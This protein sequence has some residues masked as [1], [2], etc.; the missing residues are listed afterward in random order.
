MK[1]LTR[2]P[3]F[4]SLA[5]LAAP[6]AA[7]LLL[8]TLYYVVDLYF[9]AALGDAPLA[10][11]SAAGNVMFLVFALT[12]IV[13]VG[14]VSLVSQAVGR[15][16]R[17]D[18][19][20][21]FNQSIMLAATC[22]LATL[23]AGYSLAGTYMRLLG[24]DAS[25]AAAGTAYLDWF[26]PGLALQFALVVMGSALRGTG[27][28]KPTMVV[29]A[30]TVV[31]NAA[32]APVLIAGW[33]TGRPLGV[34]GAGLASSVSV[35]AGV[36]VLALYFARFEKYV[37]FDRTQWRPRLRTWIRMLDV[38]IPAGGE[39]ALIGLIGAVV[40]WIIRD[41]G[42]AAQAGFGIGSR[43]M[44]MIFVPVLAIA[45]AAAPM[46]GQNFGAR[47]FARVRATF[48]AAAG[49]I[50]VVMTALLVLCQWKVEWLVRA[51][52]ADEAVV[53]F[54][55]QYLRIISWNFIAAGIVFTCS[56]IFQGLGNTRPAL[57]SK[58]LRLVTFVVPALWLSGRPGFA[59]VDVWH[60]S[61]ASTVLE[62]ATSL[63]LLRLQ[64]RAKLEG[65]ASPGTALGE[66][67]QAQARN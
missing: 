17:A 23:V 6:V 8:Q 49:S 25:T 48:R 58:S 43:I 26:I 38:G 5:A 34:E 10:G 54:G 51:F 65:A 28:V 24:A 15:N 20:H 52:T 44:Q 57:L 32:L 63:W 1:D 30:L 29:Q 59:L 55:T 12:Q 61:V 42:A 14:T 13:G 16:D 45:F 47:H 2:G 53:V 18:A 19:N 7:G 31:L 22:A 36:A 4:G 27:I 60:L 64:F 3:V 37:A 56:S 50:T 39:F 35:A 41:F 66:G 33:G 21:L 62:A 9:V 11:V 46:A 40:Y 67:A